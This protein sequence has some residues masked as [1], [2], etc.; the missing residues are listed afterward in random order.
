MFLSF[1]D[2]SIPLP[3]LVLLFIARCFAVLWRWTAAV[4]ALTWLRIGSRTWKQSN[5]VARMN[6]DE[7]LI[8]AKTNDMEST[9]I[10]FDVDHFS[11]NCFLLFWT[12]NFV[13]L[14][15]K[16]N[17]FVLIGFAIRLLKS[18]HFH[19]A[20]SRTLIYC[21]LSKYWCHKSGNSP[22]QA[23]RSRFRCES[24]LN[25]HKILISVDRWTTTALRW[26]TFSTY[27]SFVF[28]LCT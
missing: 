2:F 22:P 28:C 27:L 26:R 5:V 17:V 3:W 19:N 13:R 23:D 24:V 15:F 25:T 21:H 4:A 12:R 9:W 7:A 16:N 20:P 18:K 14:L 6:C 10:I 8:N 11:D 1:R